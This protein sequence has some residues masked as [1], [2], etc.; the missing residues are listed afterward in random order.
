MPS[1]HNA[2]WPGDPAAAW[3]AAADFAETH[4]LSDRPGA[5]P[6][7][8]DLGLRLRRM[9]GWM[10]RATGILLIGAALISA[11]ALLRSLSACERWAEQLLVIPRRRAVR[12]DRPWH[13]A[14]TLPVWWTDE[15][16]NSVG[17]DWGSL[18]GAS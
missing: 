17:I 12:H 2:P 15:H 14:H 6:R 10:N 9:A 11:V 5:V 18:K 7:M 1:A 4:R 3:A 16:A 13:H 8:D